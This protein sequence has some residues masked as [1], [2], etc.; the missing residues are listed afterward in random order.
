M[1]WQANIAESPVIGHDQASKQSM[2]QIRAV[3][4]DL[5]GTLIEYAGTYAS[6]PDLESPGFEAAYG[7]LN[8]NKVKLPDPE[9]FKMVGFDLLPK[10]WRQATSGTRNL[11]VPDLLTE[12]LF[13]FGIGA[14]DR[15]VLAEAAERYETAVC[16]G[17]R[18]IPHGRDIVAQLASDGFRIGLIS[19]T[20]FS[21][22]AHIVDLERYGLVEFFDVMLF[23][24]DVNMWKPNVAPFHAVL[25]RLDVEPGQAVFVGDDPAADVVGGR[26]A[27]MLTVH[28]PSSQRFSSPDGVSPDATINNLQELPEVL[29]RLNAA[30]ADDTLS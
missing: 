19:N 21:G 2:N 12:V 28:Y 17:A 7:Y 3:V 1:D 11:T 30:F 10:R 22:R 13:N 23:S 6:W 14:P 27:G 15:M 24:S 9:R 5:G 18:P 8:Q 25:E 26:R 20:M 4:F 29:A 16:A